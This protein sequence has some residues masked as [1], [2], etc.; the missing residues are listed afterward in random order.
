MYT[1]DSLLIREVLFVIVSNIATINSGGDDN[2]MIITNCDASINDGNGTNVYIIISGINIG[3]PIDG[4]QSVAEQ[5]GLHLQLLI[6]LCINI[7]I[8]RRKIVDTTR[9]KIQDSENFGNIY[10]ASV[11]LKNINGY[12]ALG[13]CLMLFFVRASKA[14]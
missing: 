13:C 10:Y 5:Q 1:L 6:Q 9:I 8:L 14:V 7:K 3:G 2:I 11:I 12:F 4:T